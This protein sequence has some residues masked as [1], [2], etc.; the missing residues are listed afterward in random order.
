MRNRLIPILFFFLLSTLAEAGCIATLKRIMNKGPFA[1]TEEYRLREKIARIEEVTNFFRRKKDNPDPALNIK[2][3]KKVTLMNENLLNGTHAANERRWRTFF[4]EF[5]ANYISFKRSKELLQ[6]LME[7]PDEAP[8]TF[9]VR[10]EGMGYPEAYRNFIAKRIEEYGNIEDLRKALD[11]EMKNTLVKLGNDYQEYRI[12][13]GNLDDLL[14]N[15]E[16]KENCQRMVKMLRENL[17]AESDK[18]S[19]I[20]KIFFEGES[21]PKIQEMRELLYQENLFVLTKLKRER[22]AE[23][24]RFLTSFLS[25]PQFVDSLF[26]Y[27]YKGNLLGK[28]RAVKLFRMIYDAQARNFHFPKINRVLFGPKEPEKSMD[29]LQNLN[30]TVDNDELLVTFSRRVDSLSEG[31]WEAVKKHAKTQDKD[32]HKRMV[33]AEEKAKARGDLSPTQGPSFVARLATLVVIGVPAVGYF[34]FDALP[35][36]VQEILY[37]PEGDGTV[38]PDEALP[39]E[40]EIIT[41]EGDEDQ[42]IEEV[43][44]VLQDAEGERGPSSNREALFTK[45]WCSLLTCR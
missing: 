30:T 19:M 12:V 26:G 40:G 36:S 33:D 1:Q 6:V 32:F 20:H 42:V 24:F 4:R 41:L 31:R 8:S 13:R 28:K 25:Q 5:E 43:G 14:E 7:N 23:I 38:D 39:E 35:T 9:L 15:P 45:W 18:N 27:I 34:Y 10:L 17:G 22:N 16:C 21:T 29:L 2:I 44:D 11:L 3:Y 37:T